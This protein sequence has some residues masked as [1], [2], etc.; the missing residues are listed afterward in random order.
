MRISELSERASVPVPT[1]KYYLREGLLPAGLRT[2]PNQAQYGDGHVH[3]LRLIRALVEVGGI[4]VATA[5]D[6]LAKLDE[7]GVSVFDVMGK[8]Q[9]AVTRAGVGGPERDAALERVDALLDRLGWRV[10]A[11]NPARSLLADV[12]ATLDRLGQAPLADLFESYAASA[13][14]IAE[15]DIHAVR[16]LPDLASIAEGVVVGSLLGDAALIALRRLADEHMARAL[17]ASPTAPAHA[18]PT[19]TGPAAADHDET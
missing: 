15:L 18:E 10:G 17:L 7:P 6:V 4:S 8:A 14:Q 11:G 9:R 19:S 1:I 16:D 5:R 3:R 13:L 12:Y 2:S